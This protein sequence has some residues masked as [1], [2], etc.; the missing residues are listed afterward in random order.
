MSGPM[1]GSSMGAMVRTALR[2]ARWRRPVLGLATLVVAAALAGCGGSASRR[3]VTVRTSSA[4]PGSSSLQ[5]EFVNVI[6]RVS[7]AVV[8]ISTP[9]D[10][11][12]GVVF[13]SRDDVVTNAHV[14]ASG[15]PYRVT[16]SHGRTYPATL[17]GEFAPDDLAVVHAQGASLSPASFANSKALRVGDIVLAIGNPLGLRSSVTNGIVSALGRTVDE[18]NGVVLPNVIQTSAPI[19]PG[20]S[21]GA[22]VDLAGQ[23]VG[24]PTLA[25]TDPQLGGAAPGIGFAIPSDVVSDIAGQI[26]RYGHVVNSHRAYL[27]VELATGVGNL[28]VVA[29]VQPGGP[30]AKAGIQPG[31]A[32]VSLAGQPISSPTDVADVLA[33]LKPGT[34]VAVGLLKPTGARATVHVKLGQYPGTS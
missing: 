32:I 22:V 30:A 5:S 17:V 33:T 1:P 18:P 2:T 19:N 34:T 16:D 20:N 12:S 4:P 13:D 29:A 15:G 6:D 25:A 31:E 27:G 24:I 14:I 7:P 10:L 21:G 8:Q 26:V 11:G 28:A 23:V 9:S 3:T